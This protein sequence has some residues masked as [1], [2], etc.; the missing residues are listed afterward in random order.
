M[1]RVIATFR[2]APLPLVKKHQ[3]F[4]V[5]YSI[6]CIMPSGI[7]ASYNSG[8]P[9]STNASSVLGLSPL[10]GRTEAEMHFTRRLCPGWANYCDLRASYSL[11]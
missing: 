10:F 5:L 11:E 7:L 3:A 4:R 6:S 1:F 2:H 9:I 8:R